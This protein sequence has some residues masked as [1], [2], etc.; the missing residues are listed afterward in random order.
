MIINFRQISSSEAPMEF[1][2][3]LDV[4]HVVKGRN[5][6]A[7]I[8]PMQVDLQAQPAGGGVIHVTGHLLAELDMSCSRCL[9][10][11][12]HRV[13]VQFEEAFKQ[14]DEDSGELDEG[15]E[16]LVLVS[17][18]RLDLTPY[19][20]EAL[21]LELPFSVVCKEDCKGL[22]PS[23]GTDLNERQ[24]GCNTER[25]DPRLAALGDFFKK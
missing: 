21:L 10:S 12:K 7:G 8:S 19:L 14:S 18:E 16:D 25:I 15:E 24:C 4:G 1:H 20:E 6:I 13:E 23:C 11:L 3:T 9:K 5:D 22:C 2:Q 17:G